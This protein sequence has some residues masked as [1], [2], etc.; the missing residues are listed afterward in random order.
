MT[1]SSPDSPTPADQPIQLLRTKLLIPPPHPDLVER[2]QLFGRL[3]A[4][5]RARLTLVTAPAGSGKTTLLSTWISLHKIEA[6]WVA[7]DSRDNDPIRFWSYLLSALQNWQPDLGRS[8]G[9]MLASPQPPPLEAILTTVMN[10]IALISNEIL[11]VLDDY[12]TI[13]NAD[14]HQGIAFILGHTSPQLH[15]LIASRSEPPLPLPAL[16]V[17]RELVELGPQDLRFSY[18]ETAAFLSRV[19]RLHIS[20]ADIRTLERQTEGWIAGLQLAAIALQSQQ[21]S[22]DISSFIHSFSGSHRYVFDY[23]AQEVL[24]QQADDIQAFLLQSSILDNLSGPACDAVLGRKGSQE[25][26]ETLEH[27]HLFLIPLDEE[28]TWYRYHH[29]FSEFLRARLRQ[30]DGREMIDELHLRASAWLD[31]QGQYREAIEQALEVEDPAWAARLIVQ[32]SDTIMGNSE[33]ITLLG[34]LDRIPAEVFDDLYSLSIT[35]AWAN[36]ATGKPDIAQ[37]YLDRAEKA[38]GACADGSALS[39]AEI[40]HTASNRTASSQISPDERRLALAE[41]ACIRAN[42]AFHKQDL[43]RVVSFSKIAQDY[44]AGAQP[45]E[46]YHSTATTQAVIAFNLSLVSEFRGDI[47][48]AVQSFRE[49]IRLSQEWKN[50]HLLALSNS[51]LGHMLVVQGKLRQADELYRSALIEAE[52]IGHR[53]TMMNGMIRVGLGNI[54]YEWD[55][56][57]IARQYLEAGIDLG[58]QWANFETLY[59]GYVGLARLFHAA[60]QTERALEEI[61]EISQLA[62]STHTP[63]GDDLIPAERAWMLLQLG[64]EAEARAWVD[65]CR[66]RIGDTIAY[67]QEEEAISL[68]RFLVALDMPE[69]ALQLI[70]RLMPPVQAGGRFGRLLEM[71]MIQA[72]ALYALG[73]TGQAAATLDHSLKLAEPE[74]Y[75]RIFLD[76]GE[77][78][79]PLLAVVSGAQLGYAKRLLGLLSK[80]KARF[81]PSARKG[82]ELVPSDHALPESDLPIEALSER[83]LEVLRLIAQGYSN[84]QIADSLV[85]SLNTTKSHVKN[86]LSRLQVENRTQAAARARQLG[87]L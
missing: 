22:Q 69:E 64:E 40:S 56:L 77:K 29:L 54:L 80:P 79:K 62:E 87:M 68:A 35:A 57:E 33:L 50:P 5:L 63:F 73:E 38:L 27:A 71:R 28:R 21:G 52:S 48:A 42:L 19:M 1:H 67:I 12:H 18:D 34:W 23:L 3:D 39:R 31:G 16:R 76:A 24:Q 30:V 15:I 36:H 32:R 11:L 44:L 37:K 6:V 55:E 43:D 61:D 25:I 4:G 20:P 9:G 66:G 46:Y 10:E 84:Q 45:T 58:K 51:H 41:I 70:E 49:T 78:L 65:R 60:G 82:P 47:P 7:L 83:E 59:P 81:Y 14:I 53:P 86:I 2:Q 13:Q 85:I 74:G 26:L 72:L 8:A 17:R 75:L